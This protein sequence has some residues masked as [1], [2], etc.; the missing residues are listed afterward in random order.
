MSDTQHSFAFDAEGV[1]PERRAAH[2]RGLADMHL[3]LGQDTAS[4]DARAS[5]LEL[6]ALWTRLAAQAEHVM[7]KLPEGEAGAA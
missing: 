2:Y 4:A 7:P 3:K 1:S 5:H 6:A